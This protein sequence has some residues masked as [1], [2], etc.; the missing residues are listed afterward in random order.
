MRKCFSGIFYVRAVEHSTA[1]CVC[2]A[3]TPVRTLIVEGSSLLHSSL[4]LTHSF[5][6]IKG[7]FKDL[8]AKR[9]KNKAIK[10]LS[11]FLSL[12]SA[13]TS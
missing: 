2:E 7:I 10:N 6:D 3:G 4:S 13:F 5:L 11:I 9:E 12:S 1:S 8:R